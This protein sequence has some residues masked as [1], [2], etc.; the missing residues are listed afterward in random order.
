MTYVTARLLDLGRHRDVDG[1]VIVA[2]LLQFFK[3]ANP[4]IEQGTFLTDF[5]QTDI[6]G[7]L[8]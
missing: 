5:C 8:F 7:P 1:K 3:L 6:F 2:P 4:V